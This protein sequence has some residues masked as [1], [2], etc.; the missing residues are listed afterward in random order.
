MCPLVLSTAT[1]V[2]LTHVA[3]VLNP[4]LSSLI[5]FKGVLKAQP[6]PESTNRSACTGSSILVWT[7]VISGKH[8]LKNMILMPL[9]CPLTKVLWMGKLE[10]V[11]DIMG[12]KV[13]K[14]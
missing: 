5:F 1:Q 12:V 9:I 11:D 6:T 2:V 7:Y 4:K 3:L 10:D 8:L 13:D 14:S